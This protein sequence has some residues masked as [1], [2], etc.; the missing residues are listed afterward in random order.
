VGRCGR[1]G[2]LGTSYSFFTDQDLENQI[3]RP[4]ANVVKQ[5]G[6]TLPEWVLTVKRRNVRKVPPRKSESKKGEE[7]DEDDD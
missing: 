1:A 7:E 2:R 6:G 4:V 5:S 3:V